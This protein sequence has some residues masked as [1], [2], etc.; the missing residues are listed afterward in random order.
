MGLFDKVLGKES[1]TITLNNAEAF[2][3]VGVAA[4]AVDG[5]I[6]PEE[7]HRIVT[8]LVT[9]RAFRKHDLKDLSST[10]N[11]VAGLIKKRGTGPVFEVVKTTLTKEETQAAFFIAADLVLA[12]GVVEPEEKKFL[13]DLQNTLELDDATALKIVE[14][15]SMKNSA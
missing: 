6:S 2:A 8:D 15:V 4:V 3:A 14:V 13:E 9:L 11:K 5:D 1:G 12:D 10:L 7:I